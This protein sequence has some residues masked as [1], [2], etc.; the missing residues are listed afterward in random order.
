MSYPVE[1]NP[2]NHYLRALREIAER[3]FEL[4]LELSKARS[5]SGDIQG[6]IQ[7]I[8]KLDDHKN[9][10]KADQLE[11][12]G[13]DVFLTD[14]ERAIR[15]FDE[16]NP[17]PR[18]EE[19]CGHTVVTKKIRTFRDGSTHIQGQC[20]ECGRKIRD[21][22]KT[23]YPDWAEFPEFDEEFMFARYV[24]VDNWHQKRL[25]FIGTLAPVYEGYSEF[26]YAAAEST[27]K[28]DHPVPITKDS[29]EHDDTRLTR[30]IYS[31]ENEA[32]VEQ[33]GACGKHIRSVSKA[34]VESVEDLPIFDDELKDSVRL[35]YSAWMGELRQFIDS[36]SEKHY[37]KIAESI[38]DGSIIFVDNS[39]F[40]S[41][42]SS[43]EWERTRQ[44]I[45]ERDSYVCQSCGRGA[46]CV[47][48]FLYER[49]GNEND[50]DL[51]SLCNRC[52]EGVHRIQDSYPYPFK[53]IPEEICQGILQVGE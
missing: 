49:L 7:Q 44:R 25:E 4:Y 40:G 14:R 35:A 52:H 3:Q 28:Y 36:E 31:K 30:R 29:C 18:I 19:G 39:R 37:Q 47:H 11:P 42:Y 2:L 24:D 50:M 20:D 23:D 48:H 6:V 5:E 43:P 9:S 41:Y 53:L 22:K 46:E 12:R 38:R 16:K 1:N 27:F 32:V 17:R 10:V 13:F 15:E 45:F 8:R 21:Y 34:K 26:D 33:C 51:I